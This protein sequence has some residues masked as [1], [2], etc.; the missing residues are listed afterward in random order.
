[1]LSLSL[2]IYVTKTLPFELKRDNYV[3]IM[4]ETFILLTLYLSLGL[5][6]DDSLMTGEQKQQF[7][8]AMIA[9]VLLNIVLNF[10]IFLISIGETLLVKLKPTIE[11]LKERCFKTKKEAY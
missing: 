5:I 6:V 7:G 4:N 1:V 3:E 10:L 9:L 2:I 8:F 11:R